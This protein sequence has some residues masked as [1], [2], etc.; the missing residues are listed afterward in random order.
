MAQQ[1]QRGQKTWD[2]RRDEAEA[3]VEA[4]AAVAETDAGHTR[5]LQKGV[6]WQLQKIN[7]R[8]FT[9]LSLSLFLS[10]ISTSSPA[11]AYPLQSLQFFLI[12]ATSAAVAVAVAEAEAEAA[13]IVAAQPVLN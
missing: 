11:L 12:S 7:T 3:E 6:S 9:L 2:T 13:A 1:W 10:V 8:D 5:W 4:E